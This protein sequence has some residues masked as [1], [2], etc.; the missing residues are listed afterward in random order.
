V[1]II[2]W[3]GSGVTQVLL[4]GN[5]ELHQLLKIFE[6]MGTPTEETWPGVTK[7][8]DWHVYPQFRARPLAE[9]CPN[10]SAD[11]LDLLQ[12]LLSLDPSTRTDALSAINHPYFDEVRGTL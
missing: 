2:E 1:H 11:G 6:L 12:G 10:L 8:Q 7:L 9:R 4:A 3:G 5:S